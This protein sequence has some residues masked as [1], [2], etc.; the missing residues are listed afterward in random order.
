MV[1]AALAGALLL[2]ALPVRVESDDC[3]SGA[4]IEQMLAAL[5]PTTPEG[6]RPDVARV[7]KRTVG[8]RIELT[9]ADGRVIAERVLELPKSY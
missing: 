4:Q 1:S 6:I 2:A 7:K 3:P 9:Q 5:L 8:L